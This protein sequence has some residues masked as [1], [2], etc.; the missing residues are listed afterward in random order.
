MIDNSQACL[1]YNQSQ[2]TPTRSADTVERAGANGVLTAAMELEDNQA[3]HQI[4]SRNLHVF[5]VSPVQSLEDD[6]Y[7]FSDPTMDDFPL[8]DLF[9]SDFS[10]EALMLE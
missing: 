3:I 2:P 4:P 7:F 6:D 1:D 5:E 9:P 8:V 10:D